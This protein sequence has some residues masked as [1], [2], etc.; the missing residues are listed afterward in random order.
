MY[1]FV[2][3]SIHSHF[4]AGQRLRGSI[5]TE[6]VKLPELQTLDLS[7][8]G[9]AGTLANEF[10]GLQT[11]HLQYNALTGTIPTRFFDSQS[12]TTRLNIGSNFMNGTL[13]SEVN[14]AS[15]LTALYVFENNFVGGIPGL[16]KMPLQIFQGQGNIFNGPLPF[17][18]FF[19]EWAE[20]IQEWWVFDNQLTGMLSSSLGLLQ[21]LQDFRVGNNFFQGPI[22][23]STYDLPNLFR[24]E[25]SGNELTGTLPEELGRLPKLV[26]VKT[27]NTSFSGTIPTDLCF[28][29]SMEVLEADCLP[30]VNPPIECFC[31]TTCCQRGTETCVRY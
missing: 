22:P 9:L 15:Q 16:G 23:P 11:L 24:F 20:T 19:G 2:S 1:C 7:H 13:P 18:L 10:R 29:T 8:N 25:V 30:D 28:S 4:I 14:L 17:D 3:I 27:Q 26:V 5:V 31:C 6:L 12:I 21:N